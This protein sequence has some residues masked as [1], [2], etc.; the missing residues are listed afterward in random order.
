MQQAE[1]KKEVQQKQLR[2]K[3]LKSLG[4]SIKIETD[5]PGLSRQSSMTTIDTFHKAK[6]EI[7]IKMTT[8]TPVTN[9]VQL[10]PQDFHQIIVEAVKQVTRSQTSAIPAQVIASTKDLKLAEQ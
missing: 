5:N 10:S 6:Q 3:H 9:I 8:P 2:L 7:P 1:K 4:T